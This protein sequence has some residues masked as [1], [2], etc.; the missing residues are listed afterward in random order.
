MALGNA[1]REEEAMKDVPESARWL[2][3]AVVRFLAVVLL[4]VPLAGQA[5]QVPKGKDWYVAGGTWTKSTE[6]QPIPST[7]TVI[8]AE[9]LKTMLDQQQQFLLVDTRN[10]AEYREGHIPRAIHVYDKEME[11]HNGKFPSDKT[12]ALVFYCNGYPD[13]PRSLNGA[14]IAMEWGYKNVHLLKGG[15]PE[16]VSKGYPIER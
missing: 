16:W 10:G 4:L 12:Y 11:T 5:Q 13:C 15:L 9:Q 6:P 7:L 8:T 1:N 3:G 14:K 2:I